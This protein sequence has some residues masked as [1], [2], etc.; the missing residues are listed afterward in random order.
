M[1][2]FCSQGTVG[3][4]R[5]ISLFLNSIGMVHPGSVP[6]TLRHGNQS[7]FLWMSYDRP[8]LR[9]VRSTDQLEPLIAQ[10]RGGPGIDV[11]DGF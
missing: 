9:I 5:R 4:S 6:I 1:L 10:N 2:S 11:A 3:R 8:Y 7:V